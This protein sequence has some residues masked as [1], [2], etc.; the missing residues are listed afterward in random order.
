MGID[1]GS[2]SQAITPGTNF[3]ANNGGGVL[4]YYNPT[5]Q[6]IISLTFQTT[7]LTGLSQDTIASSFNCNDATNPTLPNPFFLN[8]SIG[9]VAD[10]GRLTIDFFGVNPS[11]PGEVPGPDPEIGEHE[12]IPPLLP[13]CLSNPDLEDCTSVGHFLITLNDRFITDPS[14]A[15][16]GWS[17]DH[18][19]NLIPPGPLTFDVTNIGLAGVPEPATWL[20][21]A[22]ALLGMGVL[23]RRRGRG[24]GPKP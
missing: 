13:G 11:E 15:N 1:A 7:I 17:A 9:Y 5:T 24:H 22:P 14:V 8:C 21:L 6:F 10:N 20:L 4:A 19:P 2:F 18:S 23:S 16:G 12:G 3:S